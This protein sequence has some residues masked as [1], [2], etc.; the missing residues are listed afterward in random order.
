[1]S[2]FP[3]CPDCVTVP[4]GGPASIP[5]GKGVETSSGAATCLCFPANGRCPSAVLCSR[6][7]LSQGGPRIQSDPDLSGASPEGNDGDTGA[8]GHPVY[9]E[10]LDELR[11]LHAV[12]SGG[13]GTGTDPFANFSAVADLSGEPRYLYPVLRS[14]EKLTRVLSLHAQGRTGEL[15]EELL[16]VASLNVC[17][18]AML[19]ED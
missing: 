15:E 3:G 17:A 7:G 4:A 1:M 2:C 10:V 19:R 14:I 8:A 5:S 11:A 16:D 13:Y 6:S 12:K 9:H 18:A